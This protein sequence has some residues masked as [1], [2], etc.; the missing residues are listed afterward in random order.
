MEYSMFCF[1]KVL[2]MEFTSFTFVRL[3]CRKAGRVVS[4]FH[5]VK[6]YVM[7]F[8]LFIHFL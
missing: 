2:Q 7:H 6:I 5:T 4:V 8:N 3:A 1:V